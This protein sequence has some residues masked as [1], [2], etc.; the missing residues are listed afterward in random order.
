M[1]QSLFVREA[2]AGRVQ[3]KSSQQKNSHIWFAG[4]ALAP[5]V[6]VAVALHTHQTRGMVIRDQR[7]EHKRVGRRIERHTL[8]F[9]LD[10]TG[11]AC[12]ELCVVEAQFAQTIVEAHEEQRVVRKGT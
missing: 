6:C 9:S 2:L 3:T 12:A 11:V 1:C 4:A 8:H 10:R 7:R 5:S